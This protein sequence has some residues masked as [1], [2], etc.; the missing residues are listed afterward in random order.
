MEELKKDKMTL[1]EFLE[2]KEKTIEEN[3]AKIDS[4]EKEATEVKV[5]M[6][7]QKQKYDKQLTDLRSKISHL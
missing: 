4:L 6:T 2:I 5:Q 7:Q 1:R 3:A